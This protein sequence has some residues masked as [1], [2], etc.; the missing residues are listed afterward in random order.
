MVEIDVPEDVLQPILE[1]LAVEAGVGQDQIA[2][3]RAEQVT[4]R[5]ASLGCPEPGMMYIQVLTE[6]YWVVLRVNDQTFDF[7][8]D[9]QGQ[10]RLCP[11]GMG[12]D[13]LEP[14]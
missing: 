3:V 7:R 4:W 14:E 13:P 1:A 11:E 6:G 10:F 12:Q 9:S 2:I 8:V 5:D